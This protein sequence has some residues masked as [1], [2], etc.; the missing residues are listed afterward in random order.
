M[1]PNVEQ[2]RVSAAS[3][4]QHISNPS[5]FGSPTLQQLSMSAATSI[6]AEQPI[7]AASPFE[8]ASKQP[9]RASFSDT[10]TVRQEGQHDTHVTTASPAVATADVPASSQNGYHSPAEVK[11]MLDSTQSAPG[12]V[13]PTGTAGRE[14]SNI[15][16]EPYSIKGPSASEQKLLESGA[17]SP[18][19]LLPTHAQFLTVPNDFQP[20]EGTRISDELIVGKA[21]GLG[22][23]GGVYE[24]LDASGHVAP[25]VLKVC[26]QGALL[27]DLEREWEVGRILNDMTKPELALPGFM[28]IGIGIR[29]ENGKFKGMIMERL[30]GHTVD[31]ELSKADFS[32]VH[33]VRQ[34]LYEVFVSLDQA[35]QAYGFH[36]SDMRMANVMEHRASAKKEPS[37]VNT[38]KMC[39]S[40][41]R[42]LRYGDTTLNCDLSTTSYQSS[43]AAPP[44]MR[45][46]T[47]FKIID[48]GLANFD[49]DYAIVHMP[50]QEVEVLNRINAELKHSMNF[51]ERFYRWW[52]GRK[53]DV[54]HYLWSLIKYV[55]GRVWPEK[56]EEDVRKLFGLIH[57]VTGVWLKGWFARADKDK[58][59]VTCGWFVKRRQRGY[60]FRQIHARRVGFW[61]A[62]NPGLTA[63][64][65]LTQRLDCAASKQ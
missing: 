36:H 3:C 19:A 46:R 50:E 22:M 63:A 21:L 6:A 26:H 10:V 32:D 57:H 54:H 65:A 17:A 58:V 40:K 4:F 61:S 20:K 39:R 43:T 45:K 11:Q 47:Q 52:W 31:K 35:Q 18:R 5:W 8:A 24:L 1:I 30:N 2:W 51:L 55:D 34:M 25:V 53:G 38:A 28:G 16:H 33:Y 56:D 44:S 7:K 42:G 12:N 9:P 13:G 27:A 62:V 59:K 29:T 15:V 60:I 64:E 23:Q 37:R 48:Y 41:S 14:G 49:C